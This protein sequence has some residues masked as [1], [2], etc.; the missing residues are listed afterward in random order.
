LLLAIA[1]RRSQGAAMSHVIALVDDD[2]NILTSVSIALQAEGFLT[3]VYTDGQAALK[4]FADNPPDL[5]VFD[6]KMPQMDG[7]ELL[8][9]VREMSGSVGSMPVIFLTSKDDELDEALGLAMGADDYISKPFSQRLLIARIRALLRRQ[10]LARGTDAEAI[11]GE[12]E[13]PLIERGRLVMDPA[14][15][16][17]LW[18]G[19]D[20]T[21]T[22]TE[23][24]ILEALAQ[25]PGVVKSR[26]QLLDVAY[27]DDVYVD[28]R[29]I[30]SHIKRIRR[31]FRSV[32]PEFDAIETLYGVGYR[33]GEE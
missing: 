29:T 26:N 5:G 30:D 6:I 10:D 28:D 14:R 13:T 3:R 8:R 19:R 18:D 27:Q 31:K 11:S 21:L 2:R 33:F 20:V 25:R 16:K 9:R 17:V 7:M 1:L 32:D 24:L 23:F 22:V 4:A 12:E 15:H